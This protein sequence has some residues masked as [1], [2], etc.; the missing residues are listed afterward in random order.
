MTDAEAD[1]RSTLELRGSLEVR[2]SLESERLAG[3]ER[4]IAKLDARKNI[5]EILQAIIPGI[6][7]AIVGYYLNDSVNHAFQEKQLEYSTIKDMQA[8]VT[9]LE[10]AADRKV[11]TEKAIQLSMFGK[12]SLPMLVTQLD[13]GNTNSQ[14]ATEKA[15]RTLG[16]SDQKAVC[17][18]LITILRNRSRV[19]SW[20]THLVALG[21]TGDLNCR[22]AAPT[23]DEYRQDL[24]KQDFNQWV[25][26]PAEPKFIS[27]IKDV[28]EVSSKRLH[29]TSGSWLH[30]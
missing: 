22:S 8:I 17:D 27:E 7:L 6:V 24:N 28:V 18:N 15:L 25:S 13:I 21:M 1:A 12:Y 5:W 2:S 11:A 3:V 26:A 4:T 16:A 30:P 14:M 29:S 9:D 20:H 10:N 19:Y 23:V